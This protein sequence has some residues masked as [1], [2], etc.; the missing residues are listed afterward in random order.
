MRITLSGPILRTEN[1]V[2]KIENDVINIIMKLLLHGNKGYAT[3]SWKMRKERG[4]C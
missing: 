1:I 2:G 4:L 3:R